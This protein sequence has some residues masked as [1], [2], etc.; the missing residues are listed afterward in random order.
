MARWRVGAVAVALCW[1]TG[2]PAAGQATPPPKKAWELAVKGGITDLAFSP[3]ED[4]LVV[5]TAERFIAVDT[6][7]VARWEVPVTRL[8]RGAEIG[9]VAASPGCNWILVAGT[10]SS[11]RAWLVSRTAIKLIPTSGTPQGLAVSHGGNLFAVGTAAGALYLVD[12]TGQELHTWRFG[13]SIIDALKFS[14]DD[15]RLA[16]TAGSP[17]G[18]LTVAGG[19]QWIQDLGGTMA[20]TSSWDALVTWWEPPHFSTLGEVSLVDGQGKIRWTRPTHYPSAAIAPDGA[21]VVVAGVPDDSAG[22]VGER[23]EPVDN[24]FQVVGA[25]GTGISEGATPNG[26]VLAVSPG[27]ERFLLRERA[28]DADQL[29]ARTRSGELAWKL[30][31][32]PYGQLLVASTW[33]L[34]IE[35]KGDG[36]IAYR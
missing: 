14:P 19:T 24:R 11:K 18:V 20:T 12:S 10:P 15:Q 8:G 23:A 34:L 1:A 33:S 13:S 27:G 3:T 36:L 31:L 5:A 4:C 28:G 7:G 6:T 22:S 17:V 32:Y 30:A 21:Y 26:Q 25:D 35:V 2:A 16:L 29:V 9:R